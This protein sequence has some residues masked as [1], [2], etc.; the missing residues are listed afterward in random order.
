MSL[1]M[2]STAVAEAWSCLYNDAWMEMPYWSKIGHLAAGRND[3]CQ[4]D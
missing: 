2:A 4:N 1:L 3:P